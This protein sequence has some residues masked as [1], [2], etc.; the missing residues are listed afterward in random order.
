MTSLEHILR[1]NRLLAHEI[2]QQSTEALREPPSTRHSIGRAVRS[3]LE[4]QRSIA[5]VEHEVSDMITRQTGQRTTTGNSI[6]VPTRELVRHEHRALT[7][8]SASGGG[9][10]VATDQGPV[11]DFLRARS[12]VGRFGA[13]ILP[14]LR[15]NVTL[16]REATGAN[17][18]WLA[19]ETSPATDQTPTLGQIAMTPKTVSVKVPFSRQLLLQSNVDAVLGRHFSDALAAAVDKAAIAGTGASGQPTGLTLTSGVNAIAGAALDYPK[20][21]DFIVNAGAQNLDVTGFAMQVASYKLFANRARLTGGSI[22]IIHDGA[23]D[24]RPALHS[25]SVP[26]ASL[27]AGP[28]PELWIGEWG[29]VELSFDPFTSFTSQIISVV[30]MF[31]LDIAVRYPA[32]FSVASSIT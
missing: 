1:S 15:G 14:D 6:L 26:T 3:L 20:V 13:T 24:G 31:S 27:I 18:T 11:V 19:S 17:E 21:L 23:I 9:F 30:A 32:A 12:V 5:P 4:G 22:P 16:P 25:A 8:A 2:A 7:A 29:A 28:W 10:L